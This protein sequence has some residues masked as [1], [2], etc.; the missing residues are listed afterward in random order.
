MESS[1]GGLTT[2][3]TLVA[4]YTHDV[5][6][7]FD[8]PSGHPCGYPEAIDTLLAEGY[9]KDQSAELLKPQARPVNAHSV[10]AP[11]KG[12]R[13]YTRSLSCGNSEVQGA[14]LNNKTHSLARK[15]PPHE[16]Y[17]TPVWDGVHTPRGLGESLLGCVECHPEGVVSLA[18]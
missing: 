12:S 6:E 10:E 11:M 15:D 16:G 5:G 4:G 9:A 18:R 7:K 8:L 3:R 13:K 1:S 2:T 17:P 14:M